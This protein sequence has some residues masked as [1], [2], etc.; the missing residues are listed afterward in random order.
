MNLGYYQIS[1]S[2]ESIP[3]TTFALAGKVWEFV[4]MSFDLRNAP[5]TFQ[6]AMVDIYGDPNFIGI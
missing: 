2:H 5:H 6:K 1:L 3:Y 4:R